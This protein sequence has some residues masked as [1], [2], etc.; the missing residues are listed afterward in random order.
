MGFWGAAGAWGSLTL[1]W[2]AGCA[3]CCPG[4]TLARG[5]PGAAPATGGRI[6]TPGKAAFLGCACIGVRGPCAAPADGCNGICFTG[7]G[8][9]LSGRP[10]AAGKAGSLGAIGIAG[11]AGGAGAAA[12][13]GGGTTGAVF[14]AGLGVAAAAERAAGGSVFRGGRR[15]CTG[16]RK[17]TGSP[18]IAGVAFRRGAARLGVAT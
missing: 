2:A 9:G 17:G 15:A 6:G 3:L 12:A 7:R 16:G 5:A 4:M 14:F 8:C 13:R 18:A 1:G 10:G 11:A